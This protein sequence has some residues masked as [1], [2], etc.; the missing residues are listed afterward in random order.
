MMLDFS[1]TPLVS[2]KIKGSVGAGN[3]VIV[4]PSSE[5]PLLIKIKDFWL[6]SVKMPESL[7]RVAE[8]TYQ[9]AAYKKDSKN[10]LTF[11]LDVSMGSIIFKEATVVAS[12]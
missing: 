12:H 9:N 7:K 6:C 10:G 1:S 2:N 3:L 8:N 5:T 11:D 4:L